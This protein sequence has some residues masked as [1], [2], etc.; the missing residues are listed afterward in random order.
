M[1]AKLT[2]KQNEIISE[3]IGK[4]ASEN[5]HPELPERLKALREIL[6]TEFKAI[7]A[8]TYCF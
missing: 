2:L 5:Y 8:E 1:E 7:S 3:I 4:Y 6:V